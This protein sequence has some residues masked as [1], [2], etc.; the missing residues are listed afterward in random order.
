M[1]QKTLLVWVIACAIT[2]AACSETPQSTLSPTAVDPS[3]GALILTVRASR[4]TPRVTSVLM[5]SQ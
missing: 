3:T 5:A 4:S 1:Q 2:I